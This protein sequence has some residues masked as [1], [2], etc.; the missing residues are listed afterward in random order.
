MNHILAPST[1][2]NPLTGH[3]VLIGTSRKS[4]LGEILGGRPP[5]ERGWAT[6]SAVTCAVQQGAH[7]IRVHDVPSMMDV[8]RIADALWP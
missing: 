8:L 1:P 4:F 3:P 5:M 6:A 2:R 7:I